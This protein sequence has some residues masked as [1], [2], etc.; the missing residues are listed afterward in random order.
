MVAELTATI[1]GYCV[2]CWINYGFAFSTTSLGW[3]FPLAFNFI[4]IFILYATV[5]WLP[6]SPRYVLGSLIDAC[7]DLTYLGFSDGS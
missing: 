2:S 4:F 3:R 5:P 1:F 6:E 7:L